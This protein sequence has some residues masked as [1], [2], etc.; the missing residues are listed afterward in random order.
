MNGL[1][2]SC[3]FTQH[4]VLLTLFGQKQKEGPRTESSGTLPLRHY[5]ESMKVQRE[6]PS[7]GTHA[8]II[9]PHFGSGGPVEPQ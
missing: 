4:K 6:S 5:E 8:A 9:G 2:A 3:A 1:R 7:P